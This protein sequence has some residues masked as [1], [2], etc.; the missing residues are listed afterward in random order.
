MLRQSYSR[1]VDI[2]SHEY[3]SVRSLPRACTLAIAAAVALAAAPAL[4]YSSALQQ[5]MQ[6]RADQAAQT[7][8]R[9][10]LRA[11]QHTLKAD[12]QSG[13]LAAESKDSEKVYRDQLA[14]KGQKKDIAA[15]TARSLQMKEDKIVLADEQQ[16]LKADQQT[17]KADAQ[18]GRMAAES[19]D[20]E[21]VYK[22]Q[23]Y[24]RGE[25]KDIAADMASMKA[26][27]GS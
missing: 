15:D 27:S 2:A 13:R 9:M 20:A 26:L 23:Q 19:K 5:A 18:S 21:K 24:L 8:E 4:A 10:Q 12:V 6:L 3:I 22:D 17:L 16:Q 25:K 14:I 11:D 7:S 1:P